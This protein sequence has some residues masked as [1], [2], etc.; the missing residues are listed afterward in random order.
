M[1]DQD[2]KRPGRDKRGSGEVRH[3]DR[4]NAV[5]H[6]AADTARTAIQSASQV[7]RKLDISSL[8]LEDQQKIEEEEKPPPK[9]SAA[10]SAHPAQ[11]GVAKKPPIDTRT[12]GF[13]PYSS[14]AGTARRKPTAAA[15]TPAAAN[16]PRATSE[17]R[18]SWLQRL[19]RRD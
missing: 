15:P 11:T 18:R 7:L 12:R 8:S 1:A 2:D 5:W 17:P 3:D 9:T 6:W 4:G 10:A 13:D 16:R 14:T 19:L